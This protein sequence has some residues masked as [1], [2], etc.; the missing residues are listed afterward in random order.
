MSPLFNTCFLTSTAFPLVPETNSREIYS[1]HNNCIT[2][3]EST[4]HG[5]RLSA[6]G[7]CE[8]AVTVRTICGWAKFRECSDLLYGRRFHI[9]LKGAVYK[10]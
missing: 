1:K 4:Y 7:G 2:V 5:D 9:E 10:S 6:G 8:A 3:S